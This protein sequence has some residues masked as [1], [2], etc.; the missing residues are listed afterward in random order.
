MLLS[1]L[2]NDCHLSRQWFRAHFSA[3]T[4]LE[5][6]TVAVAP[7]VGSAQHSGT[8]APITPP[9]NLVEE[10]LEDEVSKPERKEQILSRLLEYGVSHL[11]SMRA[12]VPKTIWRSIKARLAWR[13]SPF[14][15]SDDHTAE[16]HGL[17]S[18]ERITNYAL[19]GYT[20][21]RMK[22]GVVEPWIPADRW[23][24]PPRNEVKD[25]LETEWCLWIAR[26][27]DKIEV[28]IKLSPN[29]SGKIK[30]IVE[31]FLLRLEWEQLRLNKNMSPTKA[32]GND[33]RASCDRHMI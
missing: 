21:F 8:D 3:E 1:A 11:S 30:C 25:S 17:H 10:E 13:A 7:A 19:D 28:E 18:L 5:Q 20:P 27:V 22:T 33:H 9:R 16:G 2:W 31:D 32:W 14:R 29:R 12:S 15:S 6:P 23:E 24:T 4:I 26:I